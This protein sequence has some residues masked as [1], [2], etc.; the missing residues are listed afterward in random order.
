MGFRVLKYIFALLVGG[1]LLGAAAVLLIPA[2]GNLSILKEPGTFSSPLVLRPLSVPS[3]I[4]DSKGNLLYEVQNG[5]YRTPVT[6]AQVPPL[7]RSAILD[8]EDHTFYQ[9]GALDIRSIG[10]AL[11]ADFSGGGG[12]QGGSTITQQLVKN[13]ILTPQR[14]LSRKFQEAILSYRLQGVMSKNQI[15]QR[16][17]NTI[18]FGEGAYGISAA[19][20]TYF[21][22]PMN[23]LD[24]AQ[25]ALLAALIENPSG[26]DPF[27]YPK[28][29]LFRRNL[30]ID[31]MLQYGTIT[32]AQDVAAKAEPLPTVSHRLVFSSPSSFV[33]EVIYR[34]ETGAKYSF[35]GS[36]PTQRYAALANDGYVIKTTLNS[37]DQAAANSAVARVLPNTN[38]KFTSAMISMNPSNGNVVAMVSGNPTKG[39]GGY[40][41]ATGRGGTGRQPGSSF[42]IFTLAAALEQGYSPNDIIDGTG[43]CKFT[44]PNTK[45]FPY[46]VSNAEPGYGLMTI[47]DATANSVN[48]AYVRLGVKIGLQNVINTA[49]VMGVTT[50]LSAVPSV[51]IGS[52]NVTPLEMATAYSVLANGGYLHPARFVTS[53]KD[54]SG[55]NVYSPV[56]SSRRVLSARIV[57][58]EDQI[59]QQVVIRGTGTAARLYG[60]PSAGK[61][62]TTDNFTD[63]W[64]D[65]FTP[66]LVTTV[67][68]GDPAGSVPM[69]DVGGAPVYGGTYPARIWH[70]YM[71]SALASYPVV[72]FP[73]VNPAW[74][75][76]S[77]FIVP[78]DS[79]GAIT[80]PVGTTTT[81]PTTITTSQPVSSTTT[82][83]VV[84]PT[85]T[86]TTSTT[87]AVTPPT[88]TTTAVTP[89]T[90]ATT[91]VSP[92]SSQ[93]G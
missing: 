5:Q 80:S 43:P 18:Y 77:K 47:T 79:P 60:R 64:F 73:Y 22:L 57:A 37:T 15:F 63:G 30:A 69:F 41:V 66:Q 4:L 62:G 21:G 35:L 45:P 65:G 2:V 85:T 25:S 26:Y 49:K 87:T 58:V 90:T 91:A 84:P 3:K 61:T 55:A 46:I 32:K 71:T 86:A 1:V 68:M 17:L 10:R 67:W 36:D 39:S 76:P 28:Y 9:H 54:Y 6:L 74:I 89:P 23:K 50:P 16:Y 24:I 56:V 78:I 53:I 38:G 7:V 31:Q 34:I 59:L 52:E 8:V 19:S 20:E 44:V 11:I 40:N 13:A 12:L 29:A 88:T 48:C 33:T 81:L 82:S 75:P 14:T 70:D 92:S 83:A 42:K 27:Y 93:P 72:Q 51:V